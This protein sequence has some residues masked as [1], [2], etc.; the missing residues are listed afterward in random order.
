M[1]S[2]YFKGYY[3][4]VLQIYF[5]FYIYCISY[6]GDDYFIWLLFVVIYLY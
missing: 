2:F 4:L 6:Y 1:I 5:I 3:R